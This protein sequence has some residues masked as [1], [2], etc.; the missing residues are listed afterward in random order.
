MLHGIP[1]P[2][3]WTMELLQ[4]SAPTVEVVKECAYL[5]HAPETLSPVHPSPC[6]F[7]AALTDSSD[8]ASACLLWL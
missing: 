8:D 7:P 3:L 2:I 5:G 1:V 6:F 4:G